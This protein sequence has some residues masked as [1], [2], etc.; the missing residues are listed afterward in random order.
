MK[1]LRKRVLKLEF[2]N[3]QEELIMDDYIVVELEFDEIITL[4]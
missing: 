1:H 4:E 3:P 2:T